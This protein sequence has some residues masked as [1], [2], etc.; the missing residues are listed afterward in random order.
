MLPRLRPSWLGMAGVPPHDAPEAYVWEKRLHGVMLSFALV[1]ILAFYLV[2]VE[3]AAELVMVG[4]L[5]EW[6]VLMAFASEL[7][8][9]LIV[10]RQKLRYLLGNWLDV[11]IV[12]AAAATV[13]GYD[14][15]WVAV[16]RLLRVA[17]VGMVLARA[18][19]EIRTLFSPGGLPYIF[20]FA[21]IAMLGAGAGFYWL[22]PSIHSYSEGLSLAF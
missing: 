20:G 6:V 2:E 4:R 17:M 13:A 19:A 22:D 15:D 5:L 11:M 7:A 21:V 1:A 12:S 10:T 8:W 16:A 14:T 18:V 3:R 9:M